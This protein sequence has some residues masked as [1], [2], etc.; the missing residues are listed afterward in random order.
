MN[1]IRIS[2]SESKPG[3]LVAARILPGTDLIP[4]LLE[5]CRRNKLTSGCIVTI[6]GSLARARFVLPIP[7]SSGSMGVRYSD[8]HE[9]EGPLEFLGGSGII[10]RLDDGE[11]TIHL[12]GIFSDRENKFCA[13]HI[14]EEG[15]HVLATMEVVIQ[16]L[17]DVEIIRSPD[18]ETGFTLFHFKE[19]VDHRGM[20]K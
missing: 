8:P 1:E 17:P 16:E 12:H 10:G 7:D 3:R 15:N 14:L 2:S 18:E 5:I 13:G 9:M 19:I 6:L 11:A 20:S 4:G